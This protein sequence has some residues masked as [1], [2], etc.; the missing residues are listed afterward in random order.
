LKGTEAAVAAVELHVGQA[1]GDR[2][3]RR[4]AVAL[5]AVSD[6]AEGAHLLDERPRE[7]RTFPVTVDDE[8]HVVVDEGPGSP[9][10]VAFGIDD[11]SRRPK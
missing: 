6:D 8:E 7:L 10:I 2:A 1:R 11:S 4:A 9:Q 3:H 5:D